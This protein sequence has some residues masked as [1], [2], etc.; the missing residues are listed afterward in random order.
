MKDV[1]KGGAFAVLGANNSTANDHPEGTWVPPKGSP[2]AAGPS[3]SPGNATESGTPVVS[4]L[5]AEQNAT[6]SGA[7]ITITEGVSPNATVG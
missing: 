2:V 5:P 4:D 7:N 6:G 3:A 1:V